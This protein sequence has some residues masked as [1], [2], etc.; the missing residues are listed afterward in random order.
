MASIKRMECENRP[1]VRSTN[2]RQTDKVTTPVNQ[3]RKVGG[4]AGSR[5]FSSS[6]TKLKS[7]QK[8]P[9]VLGQSNRVY[10][11]SILYS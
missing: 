7:E 4:D 6:K 1:S 11:T 2:Y 10:Y 8:G 9:T 5:R 3:E